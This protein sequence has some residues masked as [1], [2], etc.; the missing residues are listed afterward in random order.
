MFSAAPEPI[1]S[2]LM[3]CVRSGPNRPSATVPAT[4]WQLMQ[5]VF[6][7]ISLAGRNGVGRVR[8]LLLLLNPTIELV[9]R[10]HIDAEKHLGVLGS[11]ILRAL[12]QENTGLVRVN[13][14]AI[15]M[16]GNQV[17]L[18]GKSGNPEAVIRI[19]GE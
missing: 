16:V 11:A 14:R 10:L 8:G 2:R 7:K 12:P 6:S 4:A 3:M 13:P 15:D 9:A 18:A 17:G 5:A 1:V 19:R